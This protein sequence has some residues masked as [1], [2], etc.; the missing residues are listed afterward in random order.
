MKR[1]MLFAFALPAIMLGFTHAPEASVQ[2]IYAKH[3]GLS[4]SALAAAYLVS[5]LFDAITYPLIGHLSDL[6]Y[7]RSGTRKPWMIVGTLAMVVGLWFLYRPPADVSIV[8]YTAFFTL[9]YLGWKLTEIPY[10]AWSFNLSGDYVQRARVQLWRS[11]AM[12]LGGMVFFVVPYAA[13]ALGLTQTTELNLD[14]LAITAIVIAVGVPLLNAYALATVPDGAAPLPSRQTLGVGDWRGMVRAVTQSRAMLQLMAA[15]VPVT[16]L[17][18]MA[19]GVNY[20]FIDRYL[21]LSEQLS[22]IMLVSAPCALL[23]LPFW[24]W[25]FL[26]FERHRVLAVSLVLSALAYGCIGF[27]PVGG[28]GFW[29]VIVMNALATFG[30]MGL[31]IAAPAMTG[32]VADDE[33]LRTGEDRGGLYSGMLAF[34][35]KSLAGLAGATG[36]MLLDVLG[37]DAK[38]AVQSGEGAFAIRLI[39]AWL[40]ALGI[41][42]G[43]GL[44]WNFP[45]DRARQEATLAALKAREAAADGA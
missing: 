23:G 6:S 1:S 31:P 42:V 33:R 26:K 43:V 4:L 30:L 11:M 28:G 44:I 7:R 2:G 19:V 8:Y 32:D 22:M 40:P 37:F 41:A 35:A 24:G 16:F 14:T 29:L 25:L 13:K 38:A 21:G 18:G 12:V 45:I 27:A 15:Y 36:L 9:T 5:R 10:I 39:G 3:T 20:L 34:T 17:A